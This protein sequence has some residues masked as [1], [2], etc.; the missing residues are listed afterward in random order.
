MF[1]SKLASRA[2]MVIGAGCAVHCVFEYICDFV[3]CQGTIEIYFK[4][5]SRKVE[6]FRGVDA[7]DAIQ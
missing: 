4:D 5:I 6:S 2:G 7:A 3:I 1:L